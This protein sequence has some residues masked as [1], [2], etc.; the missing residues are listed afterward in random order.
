MKNLF[1]FFV[2]SFAFLMTT[3]TF[4]QTD[5]A[6]KEIL[7]K[8]KA[9]YD[10]YGSILAEYEL[11]IENEDM[12]EVQNGKVSQKGK[13]YRAD[14]NGNEV[15]CDGETMWMY[16]KEMNEVQINEYDP[17]DSDD[18]MSPNR[19]FNIHESEDEFIYHL[20]GEDASYSYIEFAPIDRDEVDFFK[21]R[22]QIKNSD[23]SMKSIKVFGD[24]GTRFT[25]AI[26][27]IK[28][29]NLSDSYF[30][31]DKSKYPGVEEID[32]R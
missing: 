19:L 25:I 2:A 14:V 20:A 13:K 1:L 27:S 8:V 10:Q 7:E 4:A 12:K 15:I 24:D 6:A 28:E 30:K 22:I 17:A 21:I 11:T 31:F 3:E 23:Y 5:P 9:K 16:M 29:G 18:I 26:K 32:L